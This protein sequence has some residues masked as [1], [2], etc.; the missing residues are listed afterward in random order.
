MDIKPGHSPT[1]HKG[2]EVVSM[3]DSL[4]RK[5]LREYAAACLYHV[6]WAA[7]FALIVKRYREGDDRDG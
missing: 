2:R 4:I 6:D 7:L 5:T 3:L 1:S